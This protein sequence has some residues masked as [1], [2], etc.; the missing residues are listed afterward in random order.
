[1]NREKYL[2]TLQEDERFLEKEWIEKFAQKYFH[3]VYEQ[4]ISHKWE[5]KSYLEIHSLQIQ[6][7]GKTFCIVSDSDVKL[8]LLDTFINNRWNECARYSFYSQWIENN[9][10]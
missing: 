7:K 3:T 6:Y 2:S 9:I 8:C 10:L 1:L 4:F 5:R